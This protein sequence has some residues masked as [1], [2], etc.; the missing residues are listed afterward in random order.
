MQLVI[1]TAGEIP[2]LQGLAIAKVLHDAEI[3]FTSVASRIPGKAG[4]AILGALLAGEE[5]PT[6][7][8]ELGEVGCA[9]RFRPCGRNAGEPVAPYRRRLAELDRELA[10]ALTAADAKRARRLERERG[11]LGAELERASGLGHRS[12][13]LG[14]STV[15]RARKAV[16]AR[17]RDA[18]RL[19]EA[20][21]PSSVRA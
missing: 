1:P 8:A 9:R 11:A 19:I 5:D 12:R 4:R 3:K 18:I 20:V 6:V 13:P 21:I 15:E 16:T 17:I 7:L 14:A 2:L 10:A